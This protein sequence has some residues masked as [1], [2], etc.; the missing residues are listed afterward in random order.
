MNI[1]IGIRFFVY[2]ITIIM[3][4]AIFGAEIGWAYLIGV[5]T[6]S[7]RVERK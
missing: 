1:N 7:V 4:F 3:A 6:G 2:V 5:F